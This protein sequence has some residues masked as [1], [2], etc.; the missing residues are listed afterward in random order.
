MGATWEVASQTGESRIFEQGWGG[1]FSEPMP[2]CSSDERAAPA[3]MA[4]VRK[5]AGAEFD[6]VLSV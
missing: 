2:I 1:W 5:A 4:E 6:A 3:Q